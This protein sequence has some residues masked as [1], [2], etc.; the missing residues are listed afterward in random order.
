MDLTLVIPTY[1]RHESLV[2]LLG[3]LRK[4]EYGGEILVADS[5]SNETRDL[6]R[7]AASSW[8]AISYVEYPADIAP[9]AKFAQAIARAQTEFVM[10]LADDDVAFPAGLSDCV[11]FLRANPSYSAA[12]G[13]YLSFRIDPHHIH[14][15]NIEYSSPSITETQPFDR[16]NSLMTN[17]Q[18]VTYAVQ[19]KDIALT[20]FEV[21]AQQNDLLWQELAGNSVTVFEGPVKRIDCFSHAR[22]CGSTVGYR[23]WH[24]IEWLV[25]DA[26]GLFSGFAAYISAIERLA[27]E[28]RLTGPMTADQ[29]RDA[30]NRAGLRYLTPYLAYAQQV[31]RR[32]YPDDWSQDQIASA[33]IDHWNDLHVKFPVS[34]LLRY[35]ALGAFARKVKHSVLERHVGGY[36]TTVRTENGKLHTVGFGKPAVRAIQN[37]GGKHEMNQLAQYFSH[38]LS[39]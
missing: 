17:Y 14:V 21:A 23:R 2:Q 38:Y 6:N 33:A 19:R 35:P 30:A 31:S 3:M 18:A 32:S 1:N 15:P 37:M 27:N 8:G 5:S 12:H 36:E 10:L 7:Q 39:S 11:S 22:Q 26:A 29:I 13:H 28:S 9:F 24:P 16:L 34:L 4:L 20:A 25:R